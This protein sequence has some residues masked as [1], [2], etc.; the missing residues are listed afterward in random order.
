M[1]K[2][3]EL[4]TDEYAFTLR[5]YEELSPYVTFE[6]IPLGTKL[7]LLKDNIAYCYLVRSGLCSLYH[8]DHQVLI[9]TLNK[10]GVIG[11]I[12]LG[13][14]AIA[15]V[16]VFLQAETACEIATIPVSQLQIL[17]EQHN[18]W[19][20]LS[21]HMLRRIN[22]FF[23]MNIHLTAPSAYEMVRFQ[24]IE[25]MHEPTEFRE[26]ISASLYIQQKTRL[27]RSSIM[28]I[29]SQLKQGKYVTLENGILKAIGNLPLK[30]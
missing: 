7:Y 15:G 2:E 25:L 9:G 4:E 19:D 5:L 13:G 14:N 30:Y 3:N 22:R 6:A 26:K 1:T 20:L 10:R 16:G 27:S 17:I 24:L 12:S 29:L 11:A 21:R 8:S 28:K 23:T 18:L